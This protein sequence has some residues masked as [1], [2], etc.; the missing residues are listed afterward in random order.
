MILPGI[1]SLL[2]QSQFEEFNSDQTD[3]LMACLS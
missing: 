2:K 1:D 3:E